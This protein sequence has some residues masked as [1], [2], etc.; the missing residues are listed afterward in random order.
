MYRRLA[1]YLNEASVKDLV[2]LFKE[3]AISQAGFIT[4]ALIQLKIYAGFLT[5]SDIEKELFVD[6]YINPDKG[7]LIDQFDQ[8]FCLAS[9]GTYMIFTKSI[10][11]S[12]SKLFGTTSI[13]MIVSKAGNF[14]VSFADLDKDGSL[15]KWFNR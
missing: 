4:C 12:I 9:R 10:L 11:K 6:R 15:Q 14:K 1:K 13:D 7:I 2:M 3:K 5:M 8:L